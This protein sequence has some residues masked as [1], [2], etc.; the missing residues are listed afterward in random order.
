MKNKWSI[1]T[2][3]LFKNAQCAI[4]SI[5]LILAISFITIN[6][7]WFNSGIDFS[8]G[9]VVEATC[10][11]CNITDTIKQLQNELKTT[12]NYQKID[13]NHLFKTTANEDY[14]AILSIFRKN[15]K[16]NNIKIIS[17]DFTSPQ[18]TEAFIKDSIFACIFAF[19]CIS[20]YIIAR[21]NW[22][23]AIS[24]II[25]LLLDVFITITFISIKQ[26]E[27]CLITLTAILTIIGYCIN[28]K[29]ILLDRVNKN[30]TLTNKTIPDIL[31]D[32]TKSIFFRSVFTSLTTIIVSISLLFL[33]NRP[34][35]EFGITVVFGIIIGTITSLTI[36]PNL[37]CLFKIKH[38][39]NIKKEKDPMWYAS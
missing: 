34:I 32:S 33:K 35:F 23:F 7:F 5:I 24:A 12:I 2:I 10:D 20:L 22:K 30:L 4:I 25:A 28:D 13:N 21:F 14:E 17:T 27:V 37:L 6:K 11:K 31:K 9:I 18:M 39:T 8:G 3:N 38:K 16:K 26:I 36:L 19:T 15:F 29:I 1:G